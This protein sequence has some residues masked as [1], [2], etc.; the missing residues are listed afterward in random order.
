MRV[1][2]IENQPM[3]SK[4]AGLVLTAAGNTVTTA[5][6]AEQAFISIKAEPPE[7]ILMD[8]MLPGTDG[9]A[10]VSM[11]KADPATRDIHIVAITS[12]PE[13]FSQAD[14]LAAGC[15]AYLVK[16]LNTRTLPKRLSDIVAGG[17]E[18]PR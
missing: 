14:A 3:E 13:H 8:M 12:Y 2:V 17:K 9:L 6:A 4:L 7:I 18:D 1:L 11:L 16:P 15:D 10:I 5:G